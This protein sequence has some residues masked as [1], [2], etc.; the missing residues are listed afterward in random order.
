[1]PDWLAFTLGPLAVGGVFGLL[2]YLLRRAQ[3]RD[4]SQR[5]RDAS[6]PGGFYT[7]V[8]GDHPP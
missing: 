6:E 4:A 2:V 1:M 8:Y 7:D 3:T 5:G